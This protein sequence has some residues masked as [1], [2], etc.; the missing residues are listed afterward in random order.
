M[1]GI[2]EIACV[3]TLDDRTQVMANIYD[4]GTIQ[5]WGGPREDLA[6]I[7]DLTDSM[8]A[9]VTEHNEENR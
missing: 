6:A 8:S 7:V 4:D 1:K 9:A 5:R 2:R 3:V